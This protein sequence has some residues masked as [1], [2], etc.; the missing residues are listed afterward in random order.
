M[1]N[2]RRLTAAEFD[3]LRPF[4][5]ISAERIEA[6]RSALV[7]GLPLKEIAERYGWTKQ[8]VS[9]SASKV[10]K[11]ME[12]YRESQR[13][14][15]G[16]GAELPLGWEQVT[17]IAPTHLIEQFRQEIA[18]ATALLNGALDDLPAVTPPISSP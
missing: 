13:V 15:S 16:L 10:L 4:L 5:R 2:K 3:A 11:V 6:S 17:L 9:D 8:A 1:R 7:G 14:S 18:R 12:R